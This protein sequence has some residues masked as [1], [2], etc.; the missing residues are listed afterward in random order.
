MAMMLDNNLAAFDDYLRF[1]T[2]AERE[3]ENSTREDYLYTAR[4]FLAFAGDRPITAELAKEFIK[5]LEKK[6]NQATSINRHLWALKS[7]FRFLANEAAAELRL[8]SQVLPEGTTE[9]GALRLQVD[10]MR[11]EQRIRDFADLKL[12]GLRTTQYQPKFL[13]DEEWQKLYEFTRAPILDAKT[14]AYD[15][16]RARL[17]FALLMV[18]CGAGLRLS[19]GVNLRKEDIHTDEGYIRVIGKGDKEAS[20][21]VEPEVLQ[22]INDYIKAV[23][24]MDFSSQKDS[25]YVFPGKYLGTHLTPGAAGAIIKGLCRRA[26][27]PDMHVH[28][29]RHTAG[30]QLRK[31]GADE[32]DIQDFMRHANIA[33]TQIYTG[34]VTEDLQARLPRRFGNGKR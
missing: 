8:R 2:D 4:I 18:Y 34:L 17:E 9:V 23:K 16:F 32:R 11:E 5:D 27:F 30:Y 6:G 21:P 3:K 26:G 20:V 7:Y 24:L 1:G 28:G 13:R 33:T 31:G 14:F 10:Q 19:E 12:H 22:A 25:P 29:L 15:R